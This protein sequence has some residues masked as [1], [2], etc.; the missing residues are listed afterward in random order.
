MEIGGSVYWYVDGSVGA[1][2]DR[3]V[4]DKIGSGVVG[5][6]WDV[7]RGVGAGVGRCICD[8]FVSGTEVDR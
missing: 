3:Y 1:V 8:G 2:V 7:G 6:G 4:G 5:V